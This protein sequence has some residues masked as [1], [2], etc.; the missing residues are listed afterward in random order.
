M[1]FNL[2]HKTDLQ[3]GIFKTIPLPPTL[4]FLKFSPSPG[5]VEINN[6]CCFVWSSG[7]VEGGGIVKEELG[8]M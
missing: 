7:T 1:F 5:F 4:F 6:T 3:L 8:G 2:N